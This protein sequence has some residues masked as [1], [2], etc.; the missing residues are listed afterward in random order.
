MASKKPLPPET[1]KKT[2]DR[3]SDLNPKPVRNSV[4]QRVRGGPNDTA[5]QTID[6]K[7]KP[8]Q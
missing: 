4:A 6:V 8:G 3:I 1:K 5:W 7:R 2:A